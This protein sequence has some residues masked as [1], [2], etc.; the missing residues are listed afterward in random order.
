MTA[1]AGGVASFCQRYLTAVCS[2]ALLGV[3]VV[4]LVCFEGLGQG[5][6][7]VFGAVPLLSSQSQLLGLRPP[8]ALLQPPTAARCNRLHLPTALANSTAVPY[9][10][11]AVKDPVTGEWYLFFTYQEVSRSS[12]I[13]VLES[14]EGSAAQILDRCST[15]ALQSSHIMLCWI[16]HMV[17]FSTKLSPNV[18]ENVCTNL[19]KADIRD[20]Y[21]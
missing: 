2:T 12:Q 8:S 21:T 17:L 6:R 3:F 14:P 9:Y 10:P 4:S 20:C 19:C 1:S 5:V 11:A 18:L 7:S 16:P 13:L 15:S